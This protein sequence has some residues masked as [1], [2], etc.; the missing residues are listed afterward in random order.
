M[1]DSGFA[2][3]SPIDFV[4]PWV[5]G[6]DPNWMEELSRFSGKRG[7]SSAERFRDW[8]LLRYWFRGVETFAPWVNKIHFVTWGHV[9]NWLNLKNDKLAIVK[10]SDYIPERYL[11]TFSS[12][13][14][15]LNLHRIEGLSDRFVYFNDDTFLL[16][17]IDRSYFFRKGL[18]CGTAIA[19]P[20]RTTKGVWFYEAFT[21][22]A[23]LNSH[24]EARECILRNFTKWFSPR[25]GKMW[26]RTMLMLP[27]PHFY[28][29]HSFHMPNAFLKSTFEKVWDMEPAILEK[30]CSHRFRESTDV[31]QWL[32]VWWQF[33]E[34]DFVPRS[35]KGCKLFNL[36]VETN[37]QLEKLR[38]FLM[39]GKAIIACINDGDIALDDFI[40][41]KA[42][43]KVLL[44]TLLP[45]KSSFEV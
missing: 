2:T 6:A 39:S 14:I 18:P 17:N 1:L 34:G 29:L 26:L 8:D 32:M 44:E 25:Y 38:S 11:P 24:F 45:K 16:G 31:N 30:T 5:D 13:T 7:D 9:P 10:H 28:G 36:Q 19:Q 33:A 43:I 21:N 37:A 23:V 12:H 20:I 27:Y 4:V 42:E 35:P 22:I 15:E 40:R 41:A 3:T